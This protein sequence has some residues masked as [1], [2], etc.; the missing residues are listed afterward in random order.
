MGLGAYCRPLG[1]SGGWEGAGAGG[2]GSFTGETGGGGGGKSS[3]AFLAQPANTVVQDRKTTV[4]KRLF[5][6]QFPLGLD[7]FNIG[8]SQNQLLREVQDPYWIRCINRSRQ[9]SFISSSRINLPEG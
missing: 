2:T 5:I 3:G 8:L 9:S 6:F 1:T 7:V 4:T